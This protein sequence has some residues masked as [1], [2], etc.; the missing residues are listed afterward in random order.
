MK[1]RNKMINYRIMRMLARFK[2]IRILYNKFRLKEDIKVI[3]KC[4]CDPF[5][6][7]NNINEDL[8]FDGVALGLQL[9][10]N[11]IEKINQYAVENMCFAERDASKGF[12]VKDLK[13]INNILKKDI[14]LAQYF[15]FSK[16]NV[17]HELLASNIINN[18]LS[19]YF[20]SKPKFI[21]A[22]LWWTFPGNHSDEDKQKHAHYY[23]RDIDDFKFLKLFI[24]ISDVN[25]DAGPHIVV[26]KTHQK[27][28]I[29]KI[30][31]YWVERRYK[32]IEIEQ[33]IK[34]DQVL[35]IKG[36]PGTSFFENTLCLHKGTTPKKIPRL[37]L[38][39]EWA[40]NDYHS[41]SDIREVTQKIV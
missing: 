3:D 41:A 24:Y 5:I 31:D 10:K 21:G 26:K 18:V 28:L 40:L 32:D 16:E 14:V 13:K 39:F 4:E 36:K 29:S 27:K 1:F 19:K 9:K 34:K 12:F 8:E 7:Y 25:D 30:S 20:S 33:N 2:I 37:V 11:Y 35:H 38:Q 17:V 6:Q 23:H 15:N 22:N